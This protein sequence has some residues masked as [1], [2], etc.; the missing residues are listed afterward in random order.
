MA[1]N[2]SNVSISKHIALISAVDEAIDW[3][4]STLEETYNENEKTLSG[5]EAKKA[6]YFKS[7]DLQK[8]A[9]LSDTLPTI[10][11]FKNPN[12][13]EFGAKIT[14][15]IVQCSGMMNKK[16]PTLS[17]IHKR[18]FNLL[19]VG[20]YEGVLVNFNNDNVTQLLKKP[21]LNGNITDD[22]LQAM[23]ANDILDELSNAVQN[24]K[25]T[26]K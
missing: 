8:L 23:Y 26:M 25:K 21:F 14:D 9:F 11:V 16:E 1:I 12:L 4:L 24:L 22:F 5:N 20:Y 17:E 7:H 6:H 3:D 13:F 15:I 2:L 18:I 19:F 10:F